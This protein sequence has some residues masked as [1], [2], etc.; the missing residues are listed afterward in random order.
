VFLHLLDAVEVILLKSF[1]AGG[2]VV[3]FD[4]GILLGLAGLDVDQA[5]TGDLRLLQDRH[6]LDVA[7]L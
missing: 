4:I 6:D 3:P 2:S 1:G 7:V 5:N